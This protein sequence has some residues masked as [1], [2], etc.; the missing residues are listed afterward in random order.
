MPPK[1]LAY[2]EKHAP[3]YLTVPDHWDLGNKRVDTWR[4]YSQDIRP[5]NPDYDWQPVEY[6]VPT[7]RGAKKR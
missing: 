1:V 2:I 5:E 3:D 4:A 7:G 6:P